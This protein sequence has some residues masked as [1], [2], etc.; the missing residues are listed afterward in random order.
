MKQQFGANRTEVQSNTLSVE[1]YATN[2]N[3]ATAAHYDPQKLEKQM[4]K[5][6]AQIASLKAFQNSSQASAKPGKKQKVKPKAPVEENPLL[7]P[8]PKLINKKPRPC[9]RKAT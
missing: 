7:S 8:E 4:A 5:L 9:A 1:D 2:D 3:T 6:Q